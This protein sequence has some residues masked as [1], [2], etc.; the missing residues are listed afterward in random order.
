MAEILATLAMIY[1]AKTLSERR[2]QTTSNYTPQPQPQV[3]DQGYRSTVMNSKNGSVDGV[4]MNPYEKREMPSFGEVGFMKHVNGEPV[5][6]FRN[7]HY[8]SGKM[9]NLSPAEKSL[10]GPGL[11]VGSDVPSYGGYQQLFRIKPNNVGSYR[12]TT[13]PGRSGPAGDITGGRSSLIG[14]MTHNKP[15]TTSYLPSR[16]PT[17][18]GRAQGQGGETTGMVH[19]GEHQK[20]KRPTH[21]SETSLRTDGLEFNPAKKFIS[22]RTLT[23]DPTRNK[24]DTNINY[25]VNHATPGIVSFHG[26]YINSP[27]SKAME[28]KK[29][30]SAY[31]LRP[32]KSIEKPGRKANPGRMNV[33]ANPLSQ[34]G[35]ITAIR[36]DTSRMDGWAAPANGGWNQNYVKPQFQNNNAYKG[37]MNPYAK[38]EYLNTASKQLKNNPFAHSLSG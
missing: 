30:L 15:Q 37:N 29:N 28:D 20:T 11:N 5:Y 33:R 18:P 1:V 3:D 17:V 12:L 26:G 8:V 27:A 9:N 32:P 16:Y 25:Y 14:E 19:R 10:V 21:R 31:G 36:S 34:Q 23:Q 6:D 24:G 38:N 7:R 22:N 4:G 35:M 13:L 2:P